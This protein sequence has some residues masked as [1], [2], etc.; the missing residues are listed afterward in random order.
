[1]LLLAR[2]RMSMMM[3]EMPLYVQMWLRSRGKETSVPFFR[4]ACA[5]VRDL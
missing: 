5:W 2:E 3:V 4:R 1:M